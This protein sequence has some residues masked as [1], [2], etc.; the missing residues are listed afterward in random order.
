ML[1]NILDRNLSSFPSQIPTVNLTPQ[2]AEQVLAQTFP[3][4]R[5]AGSLAVLVQG[6]HHQPAP[7]TMHGNMIIE[8]GVVDQRAQSAYRGY[9]E[10]C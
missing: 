2:E 5:R 4:R 7:T 1:T 10:T 9:D 8:P 6:H 3:R